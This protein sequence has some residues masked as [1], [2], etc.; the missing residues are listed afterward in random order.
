MLMIPP[1]NFHKDFNLEKHFKTWKRFVIQS[2]PEG[3]NV[4]ML[5]I[6]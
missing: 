6:V 2:I 3:M 5:V 4:A 1:I